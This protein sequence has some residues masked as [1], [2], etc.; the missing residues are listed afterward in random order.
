MP[1][2][3]SAAIKKAWAARRK[4]KAWK[5]TCAYC[6]KKL[7]VKGIKRAGKWYHALCYE[8]HVFKVPK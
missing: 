8:K 2:K 6:D 3:R 5:G 7:W 1:S 4:A